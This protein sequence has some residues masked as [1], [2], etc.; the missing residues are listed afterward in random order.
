MECKKTFL[1]T[2][3]PKLQSAR[4]S[5]RAS[6]VP[7]YLEAHFEEHLVVLPLREKQ[8]WHQRVCFQNACITYLGMLVVF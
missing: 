4:H 7:S 5:L 3:F 1:V 8:Y 2:L 6:S